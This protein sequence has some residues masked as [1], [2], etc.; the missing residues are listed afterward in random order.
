MYF[1]FF[2]HRTKIFKFST[3]IAHIAKAPRANATAKALSKSAILPTRN[4]GVENFFNINPICN[5]KNIN[6][7]TL[8]Q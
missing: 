6:F 4:G 7:D 1:N 5:L 8:C 2:T 3:L